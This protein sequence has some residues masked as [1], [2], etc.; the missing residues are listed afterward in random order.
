MPGGLPIHATT[1]ANGTATRKKPL[2]SR[3]AG[4]AAGRLVNA[5]YFVAERREPSGDM[6]AERREPS[7]DMIAER[8]ERAVDLVYP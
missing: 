7:G 5:I 1:A 6:V 3:V 2:R 4:R 8:R